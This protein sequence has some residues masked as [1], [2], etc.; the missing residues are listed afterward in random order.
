MPMQ[1]RSASFVPDTVDEEKRT[2]ELVWSRGSPVRRRDYRTGKPYEERLSLETEH[3][4]LSRLNGGAPLLDSHKAWN[5]GDVLGVVERAWV[6]NGEGRALVRFSEREE[7]DPI[8]A[9]VR[10]GILRN[11]SAGYSVRAYEITESEGEIP[12][13]RAVDWQ[14]MELSAVPVGADPGAGF[15]SG[16]STETPSA[17]LLIQRGNEDMDDDEQM[18]DPVVET[19]TVERDDDGDGH[20]EPPTPDQSPDRRI[21]SDDSAEASLEVEQ[22]ARQ[23]IDSE[24]QRIAAIFDA[25]SKLGL[26][27]SVA[28]ELVRD[29]IDL[30]QARIRLIDE[31]AKRDGQ[32]QIRN[33]V[34]MTGQDERT[35]RR[36]AVENA[37]L[38]RFDP[39]ANTLSDAGRDWRGMTLLEMARTF[40]EE[41]GTR[42]RGWNRDEL[43]TRALHSTS[44]FALILAGI[45]NKSLRQAYEAF[46]QTF[47]PFCRQVSASDF[48]TMHRVQLG[49]APSLEKVNEG[50]EFTRGTVGEAEETYRVETYGKVISITRQVLINDDLDAFTRI[51]QLFGVAAANLESD[52]IWSIF[53]SNPKM[54]DNTALFH[55]THKNLASSGTVLSV[56]SLGKGRGSMSKQTGLDGK[57]ILN[58]RPHFLVI[59]AALEVTAE[60]LL[61]QNLVPAK[62]ADVVPNSLRTLSVIAEPRLDTSSETAWYLIA[63]PGQ[64]DTIEYAYLEGNSGV[65]IETRNGFDVDGVEIKARLDF[66]AKAIDWRGFWRNPGA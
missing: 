30:D 64:I 39:G 52:V 54:G 44:D 5:L 31:A 6:D 41:E 14:P 43:A 51:P 2:V 15:R 24:R 38:H 49:E 13:W 34:V 20:D 36:S 35:T 23:A 7:V 8:W 56:T 42:T 19:R 17:C 61:A 22:V 48:K 12:V 9:D 37:L 3:V 57:T 21:S 60:Q 66:G 47:R 28:D 59:P 62:S 55:N 40:L 26:E 53:T 10:N 65:H 63:H 50:G 18:Q 29:G 27:R 1:I 25:Q 58:I 16:P 46:P 32:M 33:Q 4:D 11:V 45:A